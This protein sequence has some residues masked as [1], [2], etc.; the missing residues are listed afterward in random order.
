M[1]VFQSAWEVATA[2]LTLVRV[3]ASVLDQLL[4]GC[5]EVRWEIQSLQDQDITV[6]TIDPAVVTPEAEDLASL[7]QLLCDEADITVRPVDAASIPP[8]PAVFWSVAGSPVERC[9]LAELMGGHAYEPK[10]LI[11]AQGGALT[12]RRA[13]ALAAAIGAVSPQRDVQLTDA[14]ARLVGL[15]ETGSAA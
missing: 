8:A 3:D 5:V 4:R 7:R 2:G 6:E 1:K 15:Q 13:L 10:I 12:A 11:H 9:R 14:S